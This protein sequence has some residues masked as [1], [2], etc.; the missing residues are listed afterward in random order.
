M[1]PPLY[2]IWII[3]KP[4]GICLLELKVQNL[5]G[6]NPHILDGNLFSGLILS[7][8]SFTQELL[9]EPIRVFE[10][11]SYKLLFYE[12]EKFFLAALCDIKFPEGLFERIT[13]QIAKMLSHHYPALLADDF[14]GDITPFN[15][16]KEELE[17]LFGLKGIKLLQFIHNKQKEMHMISQLSEIQKSLNKLKDENEKKIE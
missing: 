3:K 15:K 14:D 17:K 2:N 5:P 1:V 9:H 7:F 4:S 16:L 6:N 12:E 13:P 11:S 8:S 10:T